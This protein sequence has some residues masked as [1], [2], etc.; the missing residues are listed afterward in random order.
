MSLRRIAAALG[1]PF[2]R[3][4]F[5]GRPENGGRAQ[6]RGVAGESDG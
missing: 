3:F 5:D 4:F 6:G 2:A 1:V